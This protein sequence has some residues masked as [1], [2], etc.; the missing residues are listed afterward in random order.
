M[1]CEDCKSKL[2][3]I[4]APDPWAAGS[5]AQKVGENKALRKG[6][7]TNPY[8]NTC[9]I[10]K[11]KCQ[12]NH[13][14][15]CTICAYAKG[16]CSICGKQVL[17][18]REY[19]MS[20]GGHG[21]HTVRD[22]EDASFKSADQMTR[23]AAQQELFEF[24]ERMGQVGRIPTKAMLEQ[25]GKKELAEKLLQLY[26]GMH[27][28]ADGMSLSKRNL[29]DEAEERKL[30]KQQAAQEKSGRAL[31]AAAELQAEG[32]Q[33]ALTSATETESEQDRP[34][35]VSV[36]AAPAPA[37]TTAS[38][39]PAQQAPAAQKVAP[40]AQKA[41]PPPPPRSTDNRW[42]YDP[43]IGLF[44]QLSTGA[45]YSQKKGKYFKNGQWLD[46]L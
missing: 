26:G 15:Y 31:E 16:L 13:A 46:Q 1:V 17:D 37:A 34:P 2:T 36:Q 29:Q 43:N 27:A 8:G 44:Y 12:Q 24:L 25:G 32:A 23:E 28:A 30:A 19:K 40:A 22:R 39:A 10:C 38:A 41:A 6:I 45:Y 4:S 5:R 20:E 11:L 42:Q 35:G 9:K 3:T 7:R 18:T 33:L 21:W 14:M